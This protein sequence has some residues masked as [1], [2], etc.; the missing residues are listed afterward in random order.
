MYKTNRKPVIQVIAIMAIAMMITPM[1]AKATLTEELT[2]EV[3]YA[4][5]SG[6]DEVQN[7]LD[8]GSRTNYDTWDPIP[9]GVWYGGWPI[10]SQLQLST[11]P[12]DDF[13]IGLAT[14]CKFGSDLIMSGAA[15][16]IVRLPVFTP[17]D[18]WSRARLNIYEINE[19][20]NWTFDR[21]E[22]YNQL[23][24]AIGNHHLNDMKI[25]FTGTDHELIFWSRDYD[26]TDVSPTN[27]NDHYTRSNRTYAI[28]DAPIKPGTY[29][30]FVTYVWYDSDK[31]VDIML[32]PDSLT[33]G[34]WNIS[35]VAI[36]NEFA[37]DSFQL[38]IQNMSISLG[39]SFDFQNG[40]GNSA[41]GLNTYIWEDDVIQFYSYVDPTT[42]NDGHYLTF[43]LPFR[44]T[45]DN[46][47]WTCVVSIIR[48]D[49]KSSI[50]IFS[51]TDYVTNDFILFSMEDA[52]SN[53][54]T[55]E[56]DG[57]FRILLSPQN[58][59]R[60]WLPMWDIPKASGDQRMNISWFTSSTGDQF[61]EIWES[62]PEFNYNPM[63]W[64]WIDRDGGGDYT[65]FWMVQHSIQ[66][67]NYY[68]AKTAPAT[69]ATDT[70]S[71][72]DDMK[73]TQK[74]WYATGSLLIKMGD[75]VGQIYYPA[76]V[77]LRAGGTAVQLIAQYGDFPDPF[78]WAWD[79]IQ[80]VIA[81]IQ[82]LG[83]WI[84]RVAQE[85]VGA[86]RWFVE[87]I[88]YYG[89]IILGL[90]IL[91]VAFMIFFIPIYISARIALMIVKAAKG[92]VSGAVDDM[93]GLAG[94]I[95]GGRA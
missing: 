82:S 36:Y 30:L 17:D 72:T 41:Y 49:T 67:N 34:D 6:A 78:G 11:V 45:L 95:T 48:S 13:Q 61:N 2:Q 24:P 16:T 86:I 55:P 59:T 64:L 35:T 37:P 10:E 21:N 47:S 42:I 62:N 53:N 33:N 89:S 93:G 12:D 9:S 31:Y 70:P 32:Q 7:N 69:G 83:Q 46:V 28:V 54:V 5:I 80:G 18:P 79:K 87:T 51:F 76:G 88:T 75:A 19:D 81:G 74:V 91:M 1:Y 25:N 15:R 22:H 65:Y 40:Y 92:D 29:Y 58:D 3:N 26:P 39:Y 68:W 56:F 52:W 4:A 23:D 57:W 38:Q 27:G 71:P 44:T 66:F 20:T 94:K 90:L 14:V 50:E 60:I 8:D 43:M 77:V 63:Q 85:V 73:F 84:W